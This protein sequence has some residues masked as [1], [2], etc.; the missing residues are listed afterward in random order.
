[1]LGWMEGRFKV[2]GSHY[3]Q[4]V[5]G[6]HYVPALSR[7]DL[8]TQLNTFSHSDSE[9]SYMSSFVTGRRKAPPL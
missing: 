2:Q 1:M 3:V 4:G 5:Q 8:S 7:A 6:S 9:P